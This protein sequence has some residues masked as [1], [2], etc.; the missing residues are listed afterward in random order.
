MINDTSWVTNPEFNS[1]RACDLRNEPPVTPQLPARS[2]HNVLLCI[3]RARRPWS[4]AKMAHPKVPAYA[5]AGRGTGVHRWDPDF[6]SVVFPP[7]H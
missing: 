4:A 6:W 7:S 3:A 1:C 5:S 2:L